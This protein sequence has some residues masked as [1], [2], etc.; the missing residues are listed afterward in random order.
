VVL[1]E[2]QGEKENTESDHRSFI[3]SM[4]CFH[5]Y[6]SIQIQNGGVRA[7]W[8]FVYEKL[9][10]NKYFNRSATIYLDGFAMP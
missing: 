1:L 6:T 9:K 2:M 7:G 3:H 8:F 10:Q 5:F 4:F